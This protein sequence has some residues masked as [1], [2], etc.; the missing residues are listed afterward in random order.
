ML[1]NVLYS[2]LKEKI[3]TLSFWTE[4]ILLLIFSFSFAPIFIWYAEKTLHEN[5]LLHSFITLAIAIVLLIL[6]E[7]ISIQNAF[8]LN[9]QS[10][11]SLLIACTFLSIYFLANLFLSPGSDSFTIVS[12]IKLLMLTSAFA[13]ALASLAFFIFGVAVTKITYSSTITLIIFLLFST[14]MGLADWPLRTLAL[15]W[16]VQIFEILGISVNA[17]LMQ[18]P[19]TSPSLVID[20]LGVHFNVASE[21]NGFGI[22][23]NGLLIGSLLSVYSKDGFMNTLS[24]IAAGLFIGFTL[25]LLRIISIILIAPFMMGIYDFIHEL[26]G[27]FFYWGAFIFTWKLLHGSLL[28]KNLPTSY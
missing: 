7:K 12:A 14:F 1:F 11:R 26:I 16:S 6:N 19:S 27:T 8:K 13:F 28:K 22:I 21:C 4:S 18:N 9:K 15:K 3:H 10:K 20:Y 25:N 23:L 17:F 24:N 2:A 5:R